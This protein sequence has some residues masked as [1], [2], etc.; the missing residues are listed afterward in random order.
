MSKTAFLFPGQGAQKPG[1]GKDFY[2][3]SPLAAEIF[4][5]AS[6]LLS[7]DMKKLCFEENDCLDLTEYTQA[8]LV[9]T[10]LAMER[11]VRASGDVYNRQCLSW[12][13]QSLTAQGQC[14]WHL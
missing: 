9:T 6:E 7:M 10:C 3:N 12:L 2:E 11:V 14:H 13:C 4:D 5:C 8:A 1:M